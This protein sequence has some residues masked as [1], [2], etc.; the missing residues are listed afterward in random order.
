MYVSVKEVI[1][2]NCT[3]LGS[4]LNLVVR[5]FYPC[6]LNRTLCPILEEVILYLEVAPRLM[7]QRI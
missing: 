4:C 1:R 2:R 3:R 6:L 5:T 7:L